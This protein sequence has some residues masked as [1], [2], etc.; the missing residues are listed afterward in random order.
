[1]KALVILAA[2]GAAVGAVASVLASMYR[3]RSLLGPPV[4]GQVVSSRWINERLRQ[5]EQ[6]W[7]E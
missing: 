3:R 7:F 5:R 2:L 6:R 1:M 4:K